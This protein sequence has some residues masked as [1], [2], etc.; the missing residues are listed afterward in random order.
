MESSQIHDFMG[1]NPKNAWT[2]SEHLGL[3]ERQGKNTK[4][5]YRNKHLGG[6]GGTLLNSLG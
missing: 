5:T 2:H 6:S 1:A 4:K 3:R